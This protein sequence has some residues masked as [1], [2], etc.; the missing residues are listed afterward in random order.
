MT[1]RRLITVAGLCVALAGCTPGTATTTSTPTVVATGPDGGSSPSAAVSEP[2]VPSASAS[3]TEG[4]SSSVGPS[5]DASPSVGP[6]GGGV[7]PSTAATTARPLLCSKEG[8]TPVPCTDAEKAKIQGQ[9]GRYAQAEKVYRDF[10]AEQLLV[11]RRAGA[12][13]QR[14]LGYTADP[15]RSRLSKELKG[16]QQDG[17]WVSDGTTVIRWVAAAPG[18]AT[19]QY[20]VVLETC[21]DSTSIVFK[22]GSEPI[23]NGERFRVLQ[24]FSVNGDVVKLADQ[25]GRG[26]C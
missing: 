18:K 5:P 16:I 11:M 14:L 21:E 22:Q 1:P 9:A 23:G 26:S 2:V 7:M 25:G 4:P 19:S 6:S 13:E 15:F 12:Q 8:S 3:A 10:V 24:A 17:T 20:P